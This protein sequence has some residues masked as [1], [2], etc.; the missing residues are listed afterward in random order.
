MPE[1]D[2]DKAIAE[3]VSARI[4]AVRAP[5]VAL[6]VA[7]FEEHAKHRHHG[8]STLLGHG[9]TVAAACG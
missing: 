9:F 3:E 5:T 2:L 1:R 6:G 8:L 4:D 7:S